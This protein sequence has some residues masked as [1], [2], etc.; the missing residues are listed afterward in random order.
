[1]RAH[2]L[3]LEPRHA[4]FSTLRSRRCLPRRYSVVV[5]FSV[6]GGD[7]AAQLPATRP[8]VLSPSSPSTT[9]PGAHSAV[10][11]G[12]WSAPTGLAGVIVYS[13]TYLRY[14]PLYVARV[15]RCTQYR[16]LRHIC[17][18]L[19]V[20]CN[21]LYALRHVTRCMLHAT[22]HVECGTLSLVPCA[23]S[24]ARRMLRASSAEL[25]IPCRAVP[26]SPPVE[27]FT[28]IVHY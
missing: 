19:H 26:G 5:L 22:S 28:R 13:G 17:C 6:G 21:Q 20:V 1:M 12:F 14:C 25:R 4:S 16:A 27:Q 3:A 7:F 8:R 9:A 11:V 18:G 15:A 23:V 10:S 2:L 24:V